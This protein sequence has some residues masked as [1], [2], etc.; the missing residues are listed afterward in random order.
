VLQEN[1]RAYRAASVN[2]SNAAVFGLQ[3]D[4]GLSALQYSNCL[5]IFF[6]PYVLFEIPSNIFLRRFKPSTWL[7]LCMLGFGLTTLAQ[8]FVKGY[9]GFLA[10]RFF[11]GVFEV[12][13]AVSYMQDRADEV[14]ADG[15]VPRL[16]LPPRD[17]V[18]PGGEPEAL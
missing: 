10:T 18:P 4:L 14:N 11:L 16:L 12:S 15:D 8:G 6:V 17:V 7:S 1:G 2:V 3:K 5:V 13:A 9:S